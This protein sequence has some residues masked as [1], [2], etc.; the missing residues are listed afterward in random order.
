MHRACAA[1]GK[2]REGKRENEEHVRLDYDMPHVFH[3]Q[4]NAEDNA[5]ALDA[6]LEYLISL[7]QIF[8]DRYPTTLPLY[9]SGVRYGRTKVWDTIPALLFRKYGDCKSLT[10]ARIAEL[11]KQGFEA[12]PVHRWIMPKGEG[13]P[14]DFH[15][16]VLTNARTPYTNKDGFEDPSKV[17]GMEADE[18]FYMRGA[19]PMA[20]QMM[21]GDP[22][23][24]MR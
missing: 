6:S 8:L 13:G 11:R 5:R 4:S 18:N 7:N 16:L 17:L 21:G 3:P 1:E 2:T 22:Y 24:M 12:R 10:A 14:T 19:V 15:I 20:N 9:R 23:R